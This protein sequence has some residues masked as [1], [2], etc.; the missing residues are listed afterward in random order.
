MIDVVLH[1]EGIQAATCLR[2]DD[3]VSAQYSYLTEDET[4]E[5]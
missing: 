1:P 2:S 4:G 3:M 5:R